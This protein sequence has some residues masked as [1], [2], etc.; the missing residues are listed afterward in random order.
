M[1]M[2]VVGKLGRDALGRGDAVHA[3]HVDI[4]E[5]DVRGQPRGHLERFLARGSRPDDLDVGL[6]RE[7]LGEMLARLGDI[8]DDDDA[9]LLGH[10]VLLSSG[11]THAGVPAPESTPG[12]MTGPPAHWVGPRRRRTRRAWVTGVP[13]ARVGNVKAGSVSE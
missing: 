12:W 9:N 8:V 4:H 5:E 3:R 6:E 1:M 11:M 10:H 7:Q 13:T 2:D